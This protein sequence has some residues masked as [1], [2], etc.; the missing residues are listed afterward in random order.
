MACQV[1]GRTDQPLAKKVKIS[2]PGAGHSFI[3]HR[4]QLRCPECL[5]HVRCD[6]CGDYFAS[7]QID[8]VEQSR[9]RLKLCPEDTSPE[10]CHKCGR[11]RFNQPGRLKSCICRLTVSPSDKP[12]SPLRQKLMHLRLRKLLISSSQSEAQ[13]LVD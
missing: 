3:L 6:H 4:S 1:C 5:L 2:P 10:Y 9:L 13:A 8:T 11:Y 7:E 12:D